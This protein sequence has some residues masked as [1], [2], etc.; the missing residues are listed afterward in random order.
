MTTPT[1]SDAELGMT[2]WNR[3]TERERAEW[4]RRANTAV[5]AEAWE[6]FKRQEFQPGDEHA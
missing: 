6:A 3:L 5:P 1:E 4:L 2:W